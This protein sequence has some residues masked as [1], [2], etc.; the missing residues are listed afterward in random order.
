MPR[1]HHHYGMN[2]AD[3]ITASTHRRARLFGS[4]RFR[5]HFT[6][7]FGE[8]HQ[9]Q[10]FRLLGWVLMPDHFHVLLWPSEQSDPSLTAHIEGYAMYAPP[11]LTLAGVGHPIGA[12]EKSGLRAR[13]PSRR[14]RHTQVLGEDQHEP[15][16]RASLQTEPSEAKAVR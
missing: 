9:E 6:Q 12:A 7:T 4:D 10:N 2:H 15:K 11:A 16:T 14:P 8:L 13:K 5:P 3:F 1:Q